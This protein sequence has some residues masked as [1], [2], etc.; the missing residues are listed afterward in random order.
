MLLASRAET[1]SALVAAV[2]AVDAHRCAGQPFEL[3]R[4][5]LSLGTIQRRARKWGDAR[6]SLDEALAIFSDLNAAVWQQKSQTEL[7]RIGGRR[8]VPGA[9]TETERQVA[10]HVAAGRTNREVAGLMFMSVNTVE[11]NLSRIYTKFG[12]RSR[13]A[14][15]THLKDHSERRMR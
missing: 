9:L 14:L 4:S 11:S 1:P 7:D 12:I 6:R 8:T 3:G 15:A 5:L 2:R 10:Q 13:T